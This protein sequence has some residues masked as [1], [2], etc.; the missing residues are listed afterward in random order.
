MCESENEPF[1]L[2][3]TWLD[4]S[5][6]MHFLDAIFVQLLRH[7]RFTHMDAHYLA[8]VVAG[9]PKLNE[10]GLG[11]AVMHAAL[12][13]RGQDKATLCGDGILQPGALPRWCMS[14]RAT[15]WSLRTTVTR[16]EVLA[17]AGPGQCLQAPVGLVA[18]YPVLLLVSRGDEGRVDIGFAIRLPPW[19]ELVLDAGL[20]WRGVAL[21]VTLQTGAVSWTRKSAKSPLWL[22]LALS[23]QELV[24]EGSPFFTGERMELVATFRVLTDK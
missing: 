12:I 21:G 8:N 6:R 1:Y 14:T 17:L 15:T 18:G 7:C 23:W 3:T 4:Q 9:Y 16:A 20:P 5:A 2:M 24:A 22:G 10:L 19:Q 13:H 11:P